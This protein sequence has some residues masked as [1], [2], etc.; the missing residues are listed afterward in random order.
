M[1]RPVERA[2][3]CTIVLA[4]LTG[5]I[6]TPFAAGCSATCFSNRDCPAGTYCTMEGHCAY[7]DT[8]LA[9]WLDE[10]VDLL[11]APVGTPVAA[12][13]RARFKEASA[14]LT[15]E[16]VDALDCGSSTGLEVELAGDA[17]RPFEFGFELPPLPLPVGGGTLLVGIEAAGRR[18]ER[19]R[20]LVATGA[21]SWIE[22]ATPATGAQRGRLLAAPLEG[23]FEG[24]SQAR[25]RWRVR[26]EQG[27]I[28]APL[29][30]LPGGGFSGLAVPLVVGANTFAVEVESG[31]QLVRCTRQIVGTADAADLL[32]ATL[33]WPEGAID[34]DL[35][36]VAPSQSLGAGDCA[37][38]NP[39]AASATECAV[40]DAWSAASGVEAL[41]VPAP[42]HTG[43]YGIAVILFS[44]P[45]ALATVAFVTIAAQG[46]QLSPIRSNVLDAVQGRVW[47]VGVATV[48][49]RGVVDLRLI[50]RVV[51]SVPTLPPDQWL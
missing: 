47:L 50:D 32:L 10:P 48:A 44:G 5:A 25:A 31:G 19:T 34:L 51:D 39:A 15:A 27:E 20:Q 24:S 29:E 46:Q 7:S 4:A 49:E 2:A 43:S 30:L 12:I 21:D 17:G 14:R 42:G 45:A 35:H 36:L 8:A 13:G 26:S 37:V 41:A 22:L 23:H 38:D 33:V 11:Y 40:T 9:L 28:E 16:L 3:V 6:A 1:S 18:I